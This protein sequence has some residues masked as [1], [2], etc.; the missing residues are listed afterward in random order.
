MEL[1]E[2]RLHIVTAF[3]I[4]PL[5][6]LANAG[7]SLGGGVLAEAASSRLAWA[8]TAGLVLG[9]LF[10]IAGATFA[11]L[12]WGWVTLPAGVARAQVWGIAAL[13]GIG[14][15]VSLFIA[16]LAYDAPTT[17][18]T[19]KVGIFAGSLLS[20]MLGAALLMGMSRRSDV[21]SAAPK[22]EPAVVDKVAAER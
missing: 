10:G 4:V 20:G 13:G 12:R 3:A 19:A 6:A 14:F 16:P 18:D 2:H 22:P 11:A 5:F 17:V 1:L 21:A 8:I 15:T 7:V 9:K